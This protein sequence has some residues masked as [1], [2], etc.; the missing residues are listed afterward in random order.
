MAAPPKTAQTKTKQAA[1]PHQVGE[2]W[3]VQPRSLC[4][5]CG[6]P[7]MQVPSG[8]VCSD[9]CGKLLGHFLTDFDRFANHAALAK[10]PFFRRTKPTQA[11]RWVIDREGGPRYY[12]ELSL[13]MRD[14]GKKP[15]KHPGHYRVGV[16]I[17]SDV[18]ARMI[19]VVPEEIYW[20]EV[21]AE[22]RTNKSTARPKSFPVT[23]ISPGRK[24]DLKYQHDRPKGSY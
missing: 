12:I 23:K 19:V 17:A 4:S 14:V 7:M 20:E 9:G 24:L 2:P 6:H 15:L 10:L 3:I 16:E 21:D 5:T 18:G 13:G 8:I 22:I 1:A 11:W